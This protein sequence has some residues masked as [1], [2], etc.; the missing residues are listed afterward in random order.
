MIRERVG[1]K[2]LLFT[3]AQP[4]RVAAKAKLAGR[5][6]LFKIETLLPL[7]SRYLAPMVPDAD[8]EKV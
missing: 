4:R 5:R 7:P 1:A 3:D 2:R 6:G 8:R